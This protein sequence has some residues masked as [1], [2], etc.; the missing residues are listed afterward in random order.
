VSKRLLLIEDDSTITQLLERR[1]TMHG[2]RVTTA[3]DGRQGLDAFAPDLFDIVLLDLELPDMNGL[4]ILPLLRQRDPVTAVL[5]FTAHTDI[6]TVVQALQLGAENFLPKPIDSALL[7]LAVDRARE[8]VV[9][10]RQTEYLTRQLSDAHPL[11]DLGG[12]PAVR[13]VIRQVEVLAPSQATVLIVGETGTGKSWL[14]QLLHTL[15]PRSPHAR[16]DVNCAG[17]SDASLDAELFGQVKGAAPGA[18]TARRGLLE[19]ADGGTLF[20]DEIGDLATELQPKLL[21]VLEGRRFRQLGGTRELEVDIRVIAATSHNLKERVQAGRFREDLYYR[22]AA[23]VIHLPPLRERGAVAITDLALRI[24]NRLQASLGRGPTQF[25]D[26]AL[27]RLRAYTWPG[28]I[29]ELRHAIE[30]ALLHAGSAARITADMLPATL[31][32]TDTRLPRPRSRDLGAHLAAAERRF[33]EA[34][35]DDV[36]GS[37]VRAAQELGISRATLYE[38][39][40]R[41]GITT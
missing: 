9:L 19:A 21:G 20:L 32:T 40:K 2:W 28:N 11:A 39:L 7:E 23:H 17:L 4:A 6:P 10:R 26:E 41:L 15:S 3:S 27:A 1:F 24:L 8:K 31:I 25:T 16:V 34:V 5:I 38:K 14:A 12:D 13:E 18:K 36:G 29:R 33:I 22:I 35:L 37:R 30:H